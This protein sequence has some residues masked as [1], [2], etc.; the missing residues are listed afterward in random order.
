MTDLLFDLGNSR[1]KWASCRTGRLATQHAMAWSQLAELEK[2]GLRLPRRLPDRVLGVSVA[3]AERE[4]W[5]E[6]QLLSHGYPSPRWLRSEAAAGGVRNGYLDPVRLGADRWLAI[7]GAWH[8]AGRRGPLAVIDAGTATTLDWVDARGRHEGGLI[9][10][11]QRLMIG[12][13]L[14]G[15]ADISRGARGR[16]STSSSRSPV[17]LARRTQDAVEAGAAL[18]TTAALDQWLKAARQEGGR[19]TQVFL[20]GGAASALMRTPALSDCRHVPDLVLRGVAF[21]ADC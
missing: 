13:L 4:A 10:P 19:R 11:G 14:Q 18:A 6:Q 15:T 1:L 12:S 7:L 17:W 2:P 9:L 3:G 8:E 16:L 20:T 5:L 21:R